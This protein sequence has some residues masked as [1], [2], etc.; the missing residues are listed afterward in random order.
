MQRRERN[1]PRLR[2]LRLSLCLIG[3]V[4]Q[5]FQRL[6]VGGAGLLYLRAGRALPPAEVYDGFDQVENGVGAVRWLQARI[7]GEAAGLADWRGKRIGQ[8][9]TTGRG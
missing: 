3:R 8:V 9:G 1:F 5:R 6:H 7:A 2:V 4:D